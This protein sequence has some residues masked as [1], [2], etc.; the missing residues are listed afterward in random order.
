MEIMLSLIG[1]KIDA[2]IDGNDTDNV[3]QL[4]IDSWFFY[5][6]K[7]NQHDNDDNS[8]EYAINYQENENQYWLWGQRSFE[9]LTL[10]DD[11]VAIVGGLY[12]KQPVLFNQQQNTHIIQLERLG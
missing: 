3:Y 1:K 2:S 9:T 5:K 6:I 10:D 12:E 4:E 11:G 7:D 8:G